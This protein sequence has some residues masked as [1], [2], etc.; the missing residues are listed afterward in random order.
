MKDLSWTKVPPGTPDEGP[1]TKGFFDVARYGVSVDHGGYTQWTNVE[2]L[3]DTK[4]EPPLFWRKATAGQDVKWAVAKV[5]D[6][7]VKVEEK[8][9]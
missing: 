5:P 6:W 1:D 3:L 2:Y 9:A 4:H 8:K 7:P